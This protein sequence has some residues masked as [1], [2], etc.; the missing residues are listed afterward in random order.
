MIGAQALTICVLALSCIVVITAKEILTIDNDKDPVKDFD[1]T[2][3]DS[4]Y[5]QYVFLVC[6]WKIYTFGFLRFGR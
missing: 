3:S 6:A 4:K 1:S 2:T 5:L